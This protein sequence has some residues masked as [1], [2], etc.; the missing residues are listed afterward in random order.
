M[1]R[2]TLLKTPIALGA[3]A[4]LG[5]QLAGCSAPEANTS[6]P[7]GE[8]PSRGTPEP[9]GSRVLLA[10]FSRA[11]ENYYYG[12]R[13]MLEVG[14][15]EIVAGLISSTIRVD[16]FRIEAAD[17]YPESY[18]ATV[19]RNV[20]EQ[21]SDAR[22]AIAGT[23]PDVSAYDAVLLGSGIW[24]VRPP[25]IMRTFVENV[26]LTGKTIYPFVTY[27]VSGLGNTVAD[28]TRLCPRST[29]GT[30]LA[31]RGEDARNAGAEVA[32]WLRSIRL[33]SR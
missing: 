8:S 10:Y 33:L 17:P 28:Y 16:T 11:G 30:P 22:P 6:R 29:I 2:R 21:G 27:A 26:D 1:N 31:I 13:T 24:N 4:L 7:E 12:D 19:Q 25:M 15:T 3:G 18:E 20:R 5:P 14:N 23:L 32:T 9:P